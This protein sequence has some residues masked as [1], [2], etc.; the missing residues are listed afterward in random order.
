M[1]IILKYPPDEQN[2]GALP[3]QSS[4][5]VSHSR[6]RLYLLPD[7]LKF[8]AA[9]SMR[10]GAAEVLGKKAKLTDF[11]L[12][13]ARLI[14]ALLRPLPVDNSRLEHRKVVGIPIGN[15][16]IVPKGSSKS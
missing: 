14:E 10:E 12:R 5:I 13:L 7:T 6:V 8:R 4:D 15:S 3:I 9:P 2:M 1:V 11:L 16:F